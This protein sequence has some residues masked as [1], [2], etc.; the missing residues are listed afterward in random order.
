M[1]EANK[2]H[3]IFGNP[4]HNLAA[5]VRQYGSEEGAYQA[6]EA[7]VMAAFRE[8]RLIV[9]AHGD[10]QQVFDMGGNAVKVRGRVVDG[11]PRIGTA[12]MP[13]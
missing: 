1:D 8:G 10:F 11:I 13:R 9:A 5:L 6:I 7:A 12:W 2:R 3:H 4:D